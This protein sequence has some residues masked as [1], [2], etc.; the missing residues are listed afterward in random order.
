[1]PGR[2]YIVIISKQ[3]EL[4]AVSHLVAEEHSGIQCPTGRQRNIMV[5][6][7]RAQGKGLQRFFLPQMCPPAPPIFHPGTHLPLTHCVTCWLFAWPLS[8]PS[9]HQPPPQLHAALRGCPRLEVGWPRPAA[10]WAMGPR[11]PAAK[12]PS[13]TAGSE[14]E[15]LQLQASLLAHPF[16]AALLQSGRSQQWE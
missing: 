10:S 15:A 9:Q 6:H 5:N 11:S 8:M 1:M 2:L 16:C 7:G 14:Q 13:R 3:G 12:R 4:A